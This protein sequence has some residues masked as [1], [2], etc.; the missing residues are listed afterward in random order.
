V[1][2]PCAAP[3][4]IFLPFLYKYSGALHLFGEQEVQSTGNN[5]RNGDAEFPEG[6][7]HRNKLL[8][9]VHLTDIT[10]A[11]SGGLLTSR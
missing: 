6:A 3:S 7:A 10:T 4:V 8:G 9:T 11:K 5:C 2:F 1:V